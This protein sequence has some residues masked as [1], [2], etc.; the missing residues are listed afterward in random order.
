MKKVKLLMVLF[1]LSLIFSITS[2]AKDSSDTNAGNNVEQKLD[3]EIKDKENPE[4]DEDIPEDLENCC[5]ITFNSNDGKN[6]TYVQYFPLNNAQKIEDLYRKLK[7]CSFT[8]EGY[9][10][11]GWSQESDATEASYKDEQT[12]PTLFFIKSGTLLTNPELVKDVH[13]YAVWTDM[14]KLIITYKKKYNSEKEDTFEVEVPVQNNKATYKM[15]KCTFEPD[16]E[17]YV[18]VCWNGDNYTGETK[19]FES[20]KSRRITYYAQWADK[21]NTFTETKKYYKDIDSDEY[22]IQYFNRSDQD[23]LALLDVPFTMEDGEFVG[24]GTSKTVTQ[25]DFQPYDRIDT[26][27]AYT[28]LYALWSRDITLT[29]NSNTGNS[30]Q[31]STQTVKSYKP[32]VLSDS[33]FTN[34]DKRLYCWSEKTSIDNTYYPSI[35]KYG[36][37]VY[38]AKDTKLYAIWS[39]PI[40]VTFNSNEGDQEPVTINSYQRF[41]VECPVELSRQGYSFIGFADKARSKA[42][43]TADNLFPVK[44]TTYYAVWSR[45]I[46]VTLSAGR[47]DVEIQDVQ[48]TADSNKEYKFPNT[49]YVSGVFGKNEYKDWNIGGSDDNYIIKGWEISYSDGT[50]ELSEYKPNNVPSNESFVL[51]D[52]T[53]K[54]TAVW[55]EPEIIIFHA[56]NGTDET[57]TQIQKMQSGSFKLEKNTFTYEGHTFKGWGRQADATN[58]SHAD[59]QSMYYNAM[60]LELYAVW[61]DITE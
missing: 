1:A 25:P 37:N 49:T 2:C 4:E 10:F 50:S 18:F 22:V 17:N 36:E 39:N 54:V 44:N 33:I 35:I 57:R 3:E 48:I 9:I 28:S 26:F 23:E 12:I 30:S 40:I 6:Q 20:D 14:S 52:N 8:R 13:F 41:K 5:T 15:A 56:N 24:W 19:E 34:E 59:E 55:N 51:Y 21:N 27:G 32:T 60:T 38:F 45:P 7:P 47:T 11:E 42:Q 46:T 53:T 31:T 29:F 58:T 61:E 16:N 43:K